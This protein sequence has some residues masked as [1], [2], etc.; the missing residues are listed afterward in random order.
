MMIPEGAFGVIWSVDKPAAIYLIL[1]GN[2]SAEQRV[3]EE[4][5][6]ELIEKYRRRMKGDWS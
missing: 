1:I 5:K 4:R 2:M 3:L 6:E